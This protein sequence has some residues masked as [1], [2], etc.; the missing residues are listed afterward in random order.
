M[1]RVLGVD[2]GTRSFDLALVENGRVVWEASIDTVRVARDPGVL[3]EAI[4]EAGEVDAIAAPSGYGVPVT[5]SHEVVDPERFAVEVLLLSTREAIEEGVER[6]DPGVMVYKALADTVVELVSWRGVRSVFIPG[7]IH[8]PTLRWGAKYNRVDIGTADKLAVTLLALHLESKGHPGDASFLLLEAGYGYNALILVESGRVTWALGGTSLAPGFITAGPLDL[9]AV[10]AGGCWGRGDVF[11]GGVMEACKASDPLEALERA[12][13]SGGPC[14]EAYE[15]M[16]E[17]IAT[18]IA[19]IAARRGVKRLLV[20]GRLSRAQRILDDLA[21]RLPGSIEP[22]PLGLLE[23]ARASKHAAQG[24]ALVVEGLLGGHASAEVRSMAIPEACGTALD[25]VW[26]PRLQEA[27]R[28]LREAYV[29]SV[30]NP[31]LCA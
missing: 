19:G 20:S 12:A 6:G 9:E 16:M 23:G 30:R 14:R 31:K 1:P 21:S 10:A 3:L 27:R 2:P 22:E 8:L 28:R 26:H 15:A 11:H 29:A 24:Y 18:T 5:L 13:A 17:S 7:I 25:H 4:R